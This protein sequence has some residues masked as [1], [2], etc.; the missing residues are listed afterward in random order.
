[1]YSHLSTHDEG[2]TSRVNPIRPEFTSWTALKH[3]LQNAYTSRS[4]FDWSKYLPAP[5][6]PL[7]NSTS[8]I[9][10][11]YIPEQSDCTFGC[12]GHLCDTAD[13]CAPNL[14]CKN[15]I[16][17]PNPSGQP[18]QIGDKCNSKQ[19]C[20]SHLRCANGECQECST[21][22]SIPPAKRKRTI[23]SEPPPF[24]PRS[25]VVAND[26]NAQCYSDTLS[27][28]FSVAA[29]QPR[30]TPPI[31]LPPNGPNPCVSTIHCD[32]NHYCN[33]GVCTPCTSKD[34]CLGA[35]CKSNNKCKTGLCN[36]FGKC[37]YPG[38]KK[39]LTGP[40][41]WRKKGNQG[42]PGVP[43]GQE[44]GPAKVRDEA[45]RVNIPGEKVAETGRV[46]M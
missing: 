10:N 23:A 13:A 38:Q 3:V 18:G 7:S 37:D 22:P 14:L 41:A 32:A 46:T 44:R 43:K 34:S 26:I 8:L 9:L 24:D 5:P 36:S 39:I 33:W 19:I 17:Q 30:D 28:I 35:K 42:I 20:Q 12:P 25:R 21:R 15:S 29:Q 16:C 11:P 6:P 1:M 2:L 45:M 4:N 31:C 40:G 27:N